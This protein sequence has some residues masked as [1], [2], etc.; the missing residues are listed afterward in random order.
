ME[1]QN[2]SLKLVTPSSQIP[3]VIPFVNCFL[4]VIL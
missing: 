4:N 3:I 1:L 2:L